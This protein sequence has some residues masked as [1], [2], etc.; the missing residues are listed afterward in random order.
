M[1]KGILESIFVPYRSFRERK[2][3]ESEKKKKVGEEE[4][5]WQWREEERR[6]KNKRKKDAWGEN[7]V[8]VTDKQK[9]Q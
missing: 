9:D 4:R 1:K 2:K 5:G 6:S 3:K 7:I 8:A